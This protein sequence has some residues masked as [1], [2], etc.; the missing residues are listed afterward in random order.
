MRRLRLENKCPV[1]LR[2]QVRLDVGQQHAVGD[3]AAQ[4]FSFGKAAEYGVVF[5][6][7]LIVRKEL[8]LVHVHPHFPVEVADPSGLRELFRV[9]PAAKGF[10]VIEFLRNVNNLPVNNNRAHEPPVAVQIGLN[11]LTIITQEV[12]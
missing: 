6:L 2:R 10:E 12:A 1:R 8:F 9:N 5:S 11:V 3:V 7:H 4:P